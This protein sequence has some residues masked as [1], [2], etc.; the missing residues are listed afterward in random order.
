VSRVYPEIT[1]ELERWI[2]RQAMFFVGT[3]PLSTDGNVNLSPKGP[4]GTLRVLGPLE[5]AYL[6]IVGSGAETAAHLRE[7]GRITVMVCAFDGPPR[8]LRI[9]GRGAVVWAEEP[10]FEPL[11]VRC[12]FDEPVVEATR[13]AIVRIEVSRVA[14][15]CGYGV[16]LMDLR[17]TRDHGERWALARLAKGGEDA[18]EAYKRG[19]NR[20]SIDGLPAWPG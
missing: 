19:K 20:A 18:I 13:R 9:Y 14:D 16:P 17:A 5:V 12:G 10:E 3:A 7:N 2:A 8:V 6:D 11:R 4:I 1:N 15:A